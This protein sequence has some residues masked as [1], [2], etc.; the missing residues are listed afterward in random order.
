MDALCA[1]DEVVQLSLRQ[2]DSFNYMGGQYYRTWPPLYS[3]NWP[4]L[5]AAIDEGL[6]TASQ[7]SNLFIDTA[8]Q[9]VKAALHLQ[10]LDFQGAEVFRMNAANYLGDQYTKYVYQ[11]MYGHTYLGQGRLAEAWKLFHQIEQALDD[12]TLIEL[13]YRLMFYE[14]L[15]AYWLAEGDSGKARSAAGRLLALAT[16]PGNRHFQAVG[17]RLLALCAQ[18]ENDRH[19]AAA[20]MEQALTFVEDGQAPLAAWR[21]HATA[22]ELHERRGDSAAAAEHHRQAATVLRGLADGLGDDDE[23]RT[24]AGTLMGALRPLSPQALASPS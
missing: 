7:N 5:V 18:A 2:R 23:S 13:R 22:A 4:Q 1:A 20:R 3:G 6:H 9:L 11:L 24:L 8:Y 15:G 19:E 10:A 17:N 14:N 12:G 16:P 21:V